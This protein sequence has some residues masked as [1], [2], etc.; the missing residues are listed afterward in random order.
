MRRPSGQALVEFALALPVV[1]LLIF[2]VLEFGRA[3]QIKI[4]LENAAREGAYYLIYDQEDADSGFTNTINA[5][6]TEAQNSGVI[7]QDSEITPQCL[8]GG[9]VNTPPTDCPQGSTIEVIVAHSYQVAVL[10]YF[11][12]PVTIQSNARMLLP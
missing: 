7:I 2:G 1:A 8:S 6:K 4:V 11:S 9:T 12:G 5:V 3:F 10:S